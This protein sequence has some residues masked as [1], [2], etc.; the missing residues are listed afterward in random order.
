MDILNDQVSLRRADEAP[1]SETTAPEPLGST[2]C[3][4]HPI[5][6]RNGVDD[7]I[8]RKD[9]PLWVVEWASHVAGCDLRPGTDLVIQL[10]SPDG[11]V[12]RLRII[13][14]T[15]RKP[16]APSVIECRLSVFWN[17][18]EI[19]SCVLLPFD[20]IARLSS[21]LG[22]LMGGL[23]HFVDETMKISTNATVE[24]RG[25]QGSK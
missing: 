13:L 9:S 6:D 14:A 22:K 23:S 12:N 16:D 10:K 17:E 19:V 20:S 21:F 25:E 18:I 15:P 11:I 8:N 24:A 5:L 1:T 4:L 2:T 3:S 7:L